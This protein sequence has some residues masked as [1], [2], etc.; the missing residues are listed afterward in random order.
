MELQTVPQMRGAHGRKD[1]SAI[2]E[3]LVPKEA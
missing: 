1:E 2:V 3:V